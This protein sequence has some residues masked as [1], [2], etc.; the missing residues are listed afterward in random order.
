MDPVAAKYVGAGLA[1]IGMGAA[2][3][4]VGII[5][6]N[7]LSGALRNPSAADGQ[8]GRAFI[9]AALS[10]GLGIFAFLVAIIL[11]FVK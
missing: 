3:I 10:E 2:A 5:F 6:G 1:G 11:L 7:F 9:G 4:G 8:F